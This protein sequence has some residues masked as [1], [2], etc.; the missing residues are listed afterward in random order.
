MSKW[1]TFDHTYFFIVL[2]LWKEM[3]WQDYVIAICSVMFSYA[4]VPQVVRGFRERR[5]TIV[6]QTA[7]ITTI[8]MYI[9]TVMFFTLGL[10][11]SMVVSCITGTLWLL[12]FLQK[13]IYH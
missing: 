11:F 10:Y 4:L 12:L 13:A 8:G 3:L 7:L 9:M 5:G 2:T 6:M 1:Y